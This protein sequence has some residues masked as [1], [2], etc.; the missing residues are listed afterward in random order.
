MA[1][2]PPRLPN[3]YNGRIY[4]L[5][6]GWGGVSRALADHFRTIPVVGVEISPLPFAI[7]WIRNILAPKSNLE[8]RYGNFMEMDISDAALVVCYLS[9][10]ALIQLKPKFENELAPEALLVSNTF[11]MPGWQFLDTR[12]A[13]DIYKSQ[14]YLYERNDAVARQSHS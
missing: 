5:G 6:C 1:I 8:L 3:I 11:K 7:A 9:R 12:T 2:L 13:Q 4:E 10:E 14:I